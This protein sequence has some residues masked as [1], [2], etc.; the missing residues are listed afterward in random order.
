[1]EKKVGILS[2]S[3][4]N[5]FKIE[6][7]PLQTVRPMQFKTICLTDIKNLNLD[8]SRTLYTAQCRTTN[9]FLRYFFFFFYSAAMDV[10]SLFNR[11]LLDKLNQDR[12][13]FRDK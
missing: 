11:R 1:M 6:A 4:D 9:F 5:R 13:E 10:L 3:P 7:I 8:V 12:R 2:I